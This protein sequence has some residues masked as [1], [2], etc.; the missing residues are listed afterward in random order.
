[1]FK[2]FSDIK[3]KVVNFFGAAWT[4]FKTAYNSDSMADTGLNIAINA[5]CN[6]Y[7]D[8][9]S[10]AGLKFGGLL[11]FNVSHPLQLGVLGIYAVCETFLGLGLV[12]ALMGVVAIPVISAAVVTLFLD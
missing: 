4:A 1:M 12:S 9:A 6:S 2:L 7:L 5:S 3:T 8:P 11:A 10:R